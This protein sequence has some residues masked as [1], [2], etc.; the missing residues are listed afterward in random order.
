MAAPWDIEEEESHG[1][2]DNDECGE[3]KTGG[4]Q[5]YMIV[6][7]YKGLKPTQFIP[8]HA[9]YDKEGKPVMNS[10]NKSQT[11]TENA[12]M[13]TIYQKKVIKWTTKQEVLNAL[14]PANKAICNSLKA[15]LGKQLSAIFYHNANEDLC[16]TYGGAHLH[17]CIESEKTAAG[18]YRRLFDIG[19][20][21]TLKAKVYSAGGYMKS[22]G[23][24]HLDGAIKHFN[25]KPRIF[26][27][28][29]NVTY[30]KVI[31]QVMAPPVPGENIVAF[32]ECLD[33]DDIEVEETEDVQREFSGFEDLDKEVIHGAMKRVNSGWE[34]QDIVSLAP[35]SK[36]P[37]IIAET[38]KEKYAKVTK[39]LCLRWNAFNIP[40]MYKAMASVIAI[41]EEKPFI[42]LWNKL[43]LKA[44][45]KSNIDLIRNNTEAEYIYKPFQCLINEYV[46][47]PTPTDEYETA[48]R[49]YEYMISWLEEQGIPVNEWVREV[50]DIMDRKREKINSMCMIGGSNSGKTTMFAMPLRTLARFCG[51]IGNRGAN[52]DFVYQE[53]VNKRVIGIDECVLQPNLME[54]MK[55]LLGGEIMT[56]NVKFAGHSIIQRTPCLLTG[57]KDLWDLD[58]SQATP[59]KNRMLY[60]KVHPIEELVEIRKKMNPKMWWYLAQLKDTGHYTATVDVLVPCPS[61]SFECDTLPLE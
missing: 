19:A 35:V 13:E 45:T 29:N 34:E 39:M 41:D 57:N 61:T 9:M 23:I 51:T 8:Q 26:M 25:T 44:Y 20:Y 38:E 16:A 12:T 10:F 49:S 37:L 11:R 46:Y 28:T 47:R 14:E 6:I 24:K 3:Q 30:F 33:T 36:K 55:L 21:K 48:E 31:K 54:D 53:C 43:A 22:Q 27:G 40:D 32:S 42:T 59:F 15:F 58:Q 52:S 18:K 5:H 1:W 2:N 50:F 4:A 7:H 56:V 60:Y 17:I